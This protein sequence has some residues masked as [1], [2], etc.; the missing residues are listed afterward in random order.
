MLLC[1]KGSGYISGQCCGSTEIELGMVYAAE[2]GITLLSDID[3]FEIQCIPYIAG[4]FKGQ[5]GLYS[6]SIRN[7]D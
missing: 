2:M 6:G 4:I 1:V 3:C 5:Q 7:P